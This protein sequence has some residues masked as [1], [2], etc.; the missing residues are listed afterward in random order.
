MRMHLL[1]LIAS[2]SLLAGGTLA[3]G[4]SPYR[5]GPDPRAYRHFLRSTSPHKV[6]STSIPGYTTTI[7]T[8]YSYQHIRVG[9]GYLS[10]R[11][12]PRG[13]ESQEV[14]PSYEEYLETPF[15]AHYHYI[16]PYTYRYYLPPPP[17]PPLMPSVPGY[18]P[19]HRRSGR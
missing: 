15:Q 13:F 17:P 10:Q 3:I 16:P 1:F 18:D 12:S 19:G 9:Q 7:V 6:Y 5:P 11:I 4:Q 2:L 14:I 8:P